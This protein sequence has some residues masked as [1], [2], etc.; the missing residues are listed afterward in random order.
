MGFEDAVGIS[1]TKQQSA[2]KEN[3]P[4]TVREASGGNYL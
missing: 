3:A 4:H 2:W 1:E